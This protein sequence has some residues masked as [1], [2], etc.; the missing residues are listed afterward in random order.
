MIFKI[1]I[2]IKKKGSLHTLKKGVQLFHGHHIIIH[3]GNVAP[4]PSKRWR[5]DQS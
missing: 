1:A 4:N 5:L 2:Y 3:A